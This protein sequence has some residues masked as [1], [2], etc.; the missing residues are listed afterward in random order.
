MKDCTPEEIEAG[1]KAHAELE[2]W[3][4]DDA[5]RKMLVDAAMQTMDAA[6]WAKAF[7]A[8]VKYNPAIATDEG[9]M[10]GWF[11]NAIMCG[12]DR[13]RPTKVTTN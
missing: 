1:R 3:S 7:V 13:K 5:E 10:I 11:A 6:V 9:T 12:Y 2:Q 4:R 8:H